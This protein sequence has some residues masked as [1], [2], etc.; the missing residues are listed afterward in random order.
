MRT[1]CDFTIL[2]PDY[3]ARSTVKV[4]RELIGKVIVRH[5]GEDTRLLARIVE[6]EAYTQDDPACHAW[7]LYDEETGT[8][9]RTGKGAELFGPPGT[10]YVY[11][12]Y[13]VHWLFNV[14]T[15]PKGVCGAVLIR[16]V[17][18]LEGVAQMKE[19]RSAVRRNVDLTNGP[20]KLTQA[21]GIDDRFHEQK[22]T[23]P[24]LYIAAPSTQREWPVE[25]S[26]RIGISKGVK[27][28]WRF[29]IPD[30]A[31]VSSGTPSAQKHS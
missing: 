15:E 2:G 4:A 10:A 26:S 11:L 9:N 25:Q 24:P 7:G 5:V 20:G 13:G 12:C 27:R 30:N 19:Y 1:D 23:A 31:F 14:V 21:L 8:W 29:F 3:Y 17:E 28:P 22:V 18:P 16:A 6:T